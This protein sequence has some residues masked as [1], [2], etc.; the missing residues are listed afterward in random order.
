MIMRYAYHYPESLRAGVEV[1]DRIN[2]R[3]G[4]MVVK[5][6]EKGVAENCATPCFNFGSGAWI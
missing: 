4:Q 2:G 6:K 1:L 3:V 5:S